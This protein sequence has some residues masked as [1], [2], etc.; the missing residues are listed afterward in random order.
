[1]K[2]KSFRLSEE[3]EAQITWLASRKQISAT[4]VIR[5][6]V[7][8]MYRQEL[9][10]L[11]KLHLKDGVIFLNDKPVIRCN[12][13]VLA[14]FPEDLLP[15]LEQGTADISE[16]ILYLILN[17]ARFKEGFEL[18]S[19]ALEEIGFALPALPQDEGRG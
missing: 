4:D 1:M 17:A 13:H 14:A 8:E 7:A 18:D 15:N 19:H 2:I 9:E 16:V 12:N 5:Q 10:R 6:A 11:P 3:T